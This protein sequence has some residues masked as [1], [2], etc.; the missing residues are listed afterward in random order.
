[1]EKQTICIVESQP[2]GIANRTHSMGTE[3][4]VTTETRDGTLVS[5]CANGTSQEHSNQMQ[6]EHLCN[7]AFLMGN[8][9]VVTRMG[10]GHPSI[11]ELGIDLYKE[12]VEVI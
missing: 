5:T 11:M 10:A 12:G 9:E 4:V 8:K 1:M 7:K 3:N 2:L 6:R